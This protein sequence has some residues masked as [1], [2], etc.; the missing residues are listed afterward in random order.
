MNTLDRC[1]AC[2]DTKKECTPECEHISEE[3]SCITDKDNNDRAYA[4]A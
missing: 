4:Q 2:S 1:Q 3:I